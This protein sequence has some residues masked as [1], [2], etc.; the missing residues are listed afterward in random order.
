[1]DELLP[2]LVTKTELGGRAIL[3][4][5]VDPLHPVVD[6]STDAS[7]RHVVRVCSLTGPFLRFG[8]RVRAIGRC[9]RRF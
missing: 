6:S 3:E 5:Q 9:G 4:I 7:R 8:R 2:V 1:M